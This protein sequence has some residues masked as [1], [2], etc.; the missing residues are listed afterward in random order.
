M[1]YI[2]F[3]GYFWYIFI[4]FSD[5]LFLLWNLLSHNAMHVKRWKDGAFMELP[6]GTLSWVNFSQLALVIPRSINIIYLILKVYWNHLREIFFIFNFSYI[7]KFFFS[8]DNNI[9]LYNLLWIFLIYFLFIYLWYFVFIWKA[10]LPQPNA[11][12]SMKGWSIY[13]MEHS[14]G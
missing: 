4:Y 3:Y 2:I 5:I 13:D 11:R 1:N 6:N 8:I 14:H 7:I 9:E 10:S 12:Q